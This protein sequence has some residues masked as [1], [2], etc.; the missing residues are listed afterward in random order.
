MTNTPR[1]TG[2]TVSLLKPTGHLT[3]GNLLVALRPMAA[4]TA[5]SDCF[6]G[7][8]DLHAL[9]VPHSPDRLR[10]LV[11][12]MKTLLLAALVPTKAMNTG[13]AS[14]TGSCNGSAKAPSARPSDS[15]YPVSFTSRL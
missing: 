2:R 4:A 5:D 6:Y 3:L 9:T 11:A 13:S 14:R 10:G 7:V 15:E 1:P 12:E 8:A